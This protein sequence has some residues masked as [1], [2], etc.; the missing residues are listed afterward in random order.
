M[1]TS[2]G[3]CMSRYGNTGEKW[4]FSMLQNPPHSCMAIIEVIKNGYEKGNGFC[5]IPNDKHIMLRY[6]LLVPNQG[7]GNVDSSRLPLEKHNKDI[8]GEI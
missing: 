3:Y 1:Q 5:V 4:N 6:L 7:Y 2:S 8:L